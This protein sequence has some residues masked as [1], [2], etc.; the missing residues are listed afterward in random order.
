MSPSIAF[1]AGQAGGT[2]QYRCKTPGE[3]LRRLGWDVAYYD[4]S[5]QQAADGRVRGEPDVL[6]I[7][8]IMGDLVPEIVRK[9]KRHMLVVYDTDD[10]FLEVPEYNPAHKLPDIDTMHEAMREADFISCSTPELVEGYARLNRTV[11]LPNYLDPDIWTGNAGKYRLAH[12]GIYLGWM[13]AFHWR[14]GDLELLK[15]W[16]PRFLAD[17]PE[18]TLVSAGSPE[19]FDYLG[20]DGLTTPDMVGQKPT[21]LSKHLRPYA[22]LP[23]MLA[24]FDIGLVPL[25]A[26][27]F[28][29]CKSSCKAQEYGAMGV[30][31]V[32]SPSRE[33]R[34]YIRPGV[35]GQLVRKNDWARRV[36]MVMDD[37]DNYRLGA[38]K[39]ADEHYVDDHISKWVMAYEEGRARR[40]L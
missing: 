8:R 26:N 10:W 35:N 9:A 19:L 36:E 6:V 34:S 21:E 28:N 7:S 20:V 27:K 2:A 24:H 31:A 11:L 4:E 29:A 14:G 13:G 39:V 17:H 12:D 3:A 5:I 15:P 23:A 32:A 37:L 38:K 22:H 30:P 1:W 18:V 25:A 33:Y 16:L 40:H